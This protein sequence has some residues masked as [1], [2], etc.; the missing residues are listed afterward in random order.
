ME[1]SLVPDYNTLAYRKG[2]E[3]D[4]K[5]GIKRCTFNKFLP[6]E[7]STGS[8]N[9]TIFYVLRLMRL[10]KTGCAGLM[11]FSHAIQICKFL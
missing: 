9:L 10:L 8:K 6:V 5:T 3:K 4:G 11:V 1:K 7:L 2:K